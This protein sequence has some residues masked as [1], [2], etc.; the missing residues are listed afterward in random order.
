MFATTVRAQTTTTTSPGR[1]VKQTRAADDKT[2]LSLFPVTQIWSLNLEKVLT[3]PP[4]FRS[5]YAVFALEDEQIAAYD[6]ESGARLWISNLTTTVQPAIGTTAVYVRTEDALVALSLSTGEAVWTQSFDDELAVPPVVAGDRVI[7]ST[8]DGDVIALRG[9]DATE[10]WRRRLSAAA[11]S[12]PAFTA[13]RLFVPTA[14]S[15]VAAL[16]VENGAVVWSRHLGGIGHDI[17]ANADRIF[18][19][20][21]DRYFYCLEVKDGEIAWRWATGADAIGRPV[22]DDRTVYFVSLDNV[23][24]AL[25][26]GSGVQ[27][28]K[29]P[30]PIRPIAGPLKYRE[31]LV[32]AGTSPTLQAYSTRDG[33]EQG[34]PYTVS[35]ELSAPPQLI[36]SRARVFPLLLTISSDIVGRA[37]ANAPPRE[38]EPASQSFVPL[39]N[40]EKVSPLPDPPVDLGVVSALPN[41]TPVVAAALR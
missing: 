38:L 4:A 37:T 40:V 8:L 10:L 26:R 13:T 28:W 41:L 6:L 15:M 21:Q 3:A 14:D 17:L 22:G 30:L 12:A 2:P 20:A 34:R 27:R 7:V 5:R 9:T 39:P 36:E 18:L 24:R 31:T 29:S 19:G 1:A 16:D 11:S 23:L 35:T 32:V 25:N 33:K